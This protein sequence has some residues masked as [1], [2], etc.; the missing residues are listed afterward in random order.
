MNKIRILYIEDDLDFGRLTKITLENDN[1]TVVLARNA[2]KGLACF[3]EKRPDLLLVDLDLEGFRDG[4]GL[5]REIKE[6]LPW[7]PVIV[8]SSHTDPETIITTLNMGVMDHIGKDCEMGVMIA[9][10]KNIARQAYC[11]DE[12]RIPVYELSPLTTFDR[13][14][15]VININ[16]SK[17]KLSGKDSILLTLLCAHSEEWVSPRELSVGLWG[18]E[19]DIAQLKRYVGNLRKILTP[20]PHILIENKSGG[21]YRLHTCL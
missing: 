13:L 1:F 16:G 18:I 4:I 6:Q 12:G 19:K 2:E 10:L 5:I 21:F 14:R 15:E 20:D 9:K 17:T 3:R 7:F 11:N 8:Y